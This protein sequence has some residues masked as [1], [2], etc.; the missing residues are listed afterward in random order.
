LGQ[1]R[2]AKTEEQIMDAKIK[3]GRGLNMKAV[4]E[5]NRKRVL[6]YFGKHPYSTRGECCE[7]LGL[8]YKT[9]QKHLGSKLKS[10]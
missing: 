1:G 5:K 9:V 8:T 3:N 2:N 7:K 10:K 6:D 4:A